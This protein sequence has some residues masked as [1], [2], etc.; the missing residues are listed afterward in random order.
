MISGKCYKSN[1]YIGLSDRK[2]GASDYLYER[3]YRALAPNDIFI[4]LELDLV[5][6]E[7]KL[8]FEGKIYWIITEGITHET[9]L[10]FVQEL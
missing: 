7:I 9:F 2:R 1:C 4:L 10:D 3:Y 6:K 8:L 5:S